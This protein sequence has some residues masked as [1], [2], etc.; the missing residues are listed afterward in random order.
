[1]SEPSNEQNQTI[2]RHLKTL[3]RGLTQNELTEE[4]YRSYKALF[5]IGDPAISQIR[6]VLL[7]FD[8]S[9]GRFKT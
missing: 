2:S 8:F 7:K 3:I 9:R 1:M 4:T 6:D 5:Q